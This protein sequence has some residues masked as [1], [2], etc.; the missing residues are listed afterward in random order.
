[1]VGLGDLEDLFQPRWFYDLNYPGHNPP[2]PTTQV[3][4]WRWPFSPVLQDQ[5]CAST[6]SCPVSITSFVSQNLSPLA[7][8]VASWWDFHGPC[9]WGCEVK[10]ETVTLKALQEHQRL[11][12]SA[13]WRLVE[14]S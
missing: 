8:E 9:S 11:T 13:Q 5:P 3:T 14:N 7:Q 6:T 1:M 4:R 12:N 2:F 10:E